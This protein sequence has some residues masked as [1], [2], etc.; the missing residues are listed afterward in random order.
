M[1]SRLETGVQLIV[2]LTLE[3]SDVPHWHSTNDATFRNICNPT[4]VRIS[5]MTSA[6]IV[7]IVDGG[8]RTAVAQIRAI[9]WVAAFA[10]PNRLLLLYT[11]MRE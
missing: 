1:R 5:L 11:L 3:F 2:V 8:A 9:H 7:L 4:R 10:R 6:Y